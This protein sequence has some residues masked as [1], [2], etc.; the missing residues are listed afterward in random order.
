MLNFLNQL[1]NK[2][3]NNTVY[4]EEFGIYFVKKQVERIRNMKIEIYSNDH[5]PPHFHV[6][7]NDKTIN[8]V[9]SLKDCS[10]LKGTIRGKDKKRIEAFFKDQKIQ[11]I[12]QK[13]WKES[14]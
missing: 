10:L 13:M 9:F 14:K 1:L 11:I 7:S 2:Y 3:I 8:A 4:H 5:N 6:K 12:M